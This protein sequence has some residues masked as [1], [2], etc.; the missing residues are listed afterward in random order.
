M[1]DRV[2]APEC[3]ENIA[4]V[5]DFIA[6]IMRNEKAEILAFFAEQACY[7]NIPMEPRQ[8]REEIWQELSIIHSLASA[9]DWQLHHIGS[10]EGGCVFTE[11]S[12]R[13]QVR[14]Q[15]VSF[16]VMGIFEIV[17]GRIM[18]WRDYFDLQQCMQQLS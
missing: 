14:G 6:A 1:I 12:D 2:K 5:K 18:H 9:I 16:K 13:Y 7:H 11:R 4:L 15:W 10:G 8:G 3:V 17:D